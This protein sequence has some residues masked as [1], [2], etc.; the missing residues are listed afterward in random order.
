MNRLSDDMRRLAVLSA[1][2]ADERVT[3]RAMASRLGVSLGLVNGLFRRMAS[4]RLI[5][6]SQ[7]A[8]SRQARY[9]VTA[10]GR[11]A[12]HRTGSTLARAAG[13]MLAAP[14]AAFERE[15]RRLK[16]EGARKILLCGSGPLA[17]VAASALRN[18]GLNLGGVVARDTNAGRVAG[19]RARHL[20]HAGQTRCHAA[21]VVNSR[22]AAVL[23]RHLGKGVPMIPFLP[24]VRRAEKRR[25]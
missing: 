21:V 11:R 25:G 3:Q 19:I 18:A 22:D 9:R 24:P 12:L 10:A 23:R 13:D 7:A 16:A 6:L 20:R 14:R 15:A 5:A 1:L 17:D 2:A 4:E 8:Q